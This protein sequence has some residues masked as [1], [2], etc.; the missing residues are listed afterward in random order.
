M[1]DGGRSKRL[2]GSEE[3]AVVIRLETALPDTEVRCGVCF[4]P[5]SQ[6]PGVR[7]EHPE[8]VRLRDP[9]AYEVRAC[10]PAGALA[11]GRYR[12]H[13]DAIVASA[14]GEE[15]NAIRRDVGRVKIAGDH[16][17][18]TEPA[19]E[20]VEHWDGCV[21]RRVEAEWSIE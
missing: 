18:P 21:S 17:S 19:G 14:A 5:P 4:T 20:P 16:P 15:A 10:V 9:R 13:A 2:P 11:P 1:S 12:V 8:P 6:E 3:L 7:V